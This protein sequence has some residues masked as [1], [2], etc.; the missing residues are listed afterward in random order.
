MDL[1][2]FNNGGEITSRHGVAGIPPENFQQALRDTGSDLIESTKR[3]EDSSVV[4]AALASEVDTLARQLGH[5]PPPD[6]GQ[7]VPR[8]DT[9]AAYQQAAPQ[10][11]PSP[12]TPGTLEDRIRR[13]MEKYSSPEELAK[14][15]DHAQRAV[16][17]VGQSR[18]REV[19]DL[20]MENARLE[21][22]LQQARMQQTYQRRPEPTEEADDMPT[23]HT[24]GAVPE[25]PEKFFQKPAKNFSEL[26]RG[27][28]RDEI[29]QMNEAQRIA[30]EEAEFEEKR[31]ENADRIEALR[32]VMNQIYQQDIDLYEAL[33]KDRALDLLLERATERY[34][35]MRARTFFDD[36]R[37]ETGIGGTPANAAPQQTGA[38]PTGSGSGRRPGGSQ[39]VSDWSQTP[40]FNRLWKARS[41]SV[42]EDRAI[43]SILRERGFGEDIPL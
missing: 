39:A 6:L 31:Q 43:T 23:G 13:V 7:Q 28:I 12:A 1:P 18:S 9:P 3:P 11:P 21:N 26:M 38:L 41:E 25:D 37:K 17:Q 32:P 19:S 35:A 22:E 10:A 15:Y 29:A 2:E 24:S 14:A 34:E 40:N 20:R 33:P 5:H 8:Q 16:T 27:V 30:A 4:Q 36:L 42:E